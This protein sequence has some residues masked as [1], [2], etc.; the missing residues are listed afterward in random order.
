MS[1]VTKLGLQKQISWTRPRPNSD[2]HTLPPGFSRNR[3]QGTAS[4]LDAEVDPAGP[5]RS[6][7][8]NITTM[9]TVVTQVQTTQ[10]LNNSHNPNFSNSVL[11]NVNGNS[12]TNHYY[13]DPRALRILPDGSFRLRNDEVDSS[14]VPH[15]TMSRDP[16]DDAVPDAHSESESPSESSRPTNDSAD[17][18]LRE[19]SVPSDSDRFVV[20][21]VRLTLSPEIFE[22]PFFFFT[23]SHHIASLSFPDLFPDY[24]WYRFGQDLVQKSQTPTLLF[25]QVDGLPLIRTPINGS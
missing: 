25:G 12:V 19:D 11:S 22:L 3:E 5:F 10:I 20:I 2:I 7:S 17:Q 24:N 18:S 15:T 6:V 14:E 1:V 23:R 16:V 4:A 13:L 8:A 21:E 9:N